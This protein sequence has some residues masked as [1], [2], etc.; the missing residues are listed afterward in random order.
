MEPPGVLVVVVVD[1][2]LLEVEVVFVVDVVL[3]EEDVVVEVLEE[4]VALVE[5]VLVAELCT[6]ASHAI[7]QYSV[8]VPKLQLEADS[9]VDDT[10]Y[11]A[12]KP[13]VPLPENS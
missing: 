6:K 3:L 2:V 12:V 4:D 9:G 13:C 1:V 11:S 5:V 10:E 7:P 8:D